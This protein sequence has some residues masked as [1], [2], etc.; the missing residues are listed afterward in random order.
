MLNEPILIVGTGALATLFAARLA[1]RG[2]DITMLGTWRGGT[3]SARLATAHASRIQRAAHVP[4]ASASR[5]TRGRCRGA[6]YAFVLVKS[7][8]TE[9]AAHQLAECLAQDGLALTLQNGLGNDDILS[10]ALG[11]ARVALGV[12]TTGATLL[13]PGLVRPGGEGVISLEAHPAAGNAGDRSKRGG[14][15]GRS[16]GGRAFARLGQTG[17]Q[18]GHQSADRITANTQWRIVES[19]LGACHHE[20]PCQRDRRGGLRPAGMPAVHGIPLRRQ[21]R[22][23]ARPPPIILPCSRMYA[24]AHR[25]RSMPFAVRSRVQAKRHGVPT[26]VNR[27]CWQ[28]CRPWQPEVRLRF[29]GKIRPF[30]LLEEQEHAADF[31][32]AVAFRIAAVITTCIRAG[33]SHAGA[34]RI[35]GS[36]PSMISRRCLSSSAFWFLETPPCPHA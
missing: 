9:R 22:W 5:A 23:H 2:H 34:P 11:R 12:T 19:S 28:L 16:G 32:S 4:S 14:L 18:R 6:K 33:K 25:P 31:Y 13:G 35:Y 30:I 7:W 15:P 10:R 21:S 8:Q 26:P 3:G 36:G 27:V 17:G 20:G 24:A 1:E 29:H